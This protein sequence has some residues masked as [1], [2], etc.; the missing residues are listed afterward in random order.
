MNILLSYGVRVSKVSYPKISNEH[1]R[2]RVGNQEML[3]NKQQDES[4]AVDNRIFST[5][6][7]KGYKS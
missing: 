6:L 1:R 2:R 4:P 7:N 5:L 3:I